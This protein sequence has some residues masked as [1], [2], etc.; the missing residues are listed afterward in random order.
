MTFGVG[1]TLR[2]LAALGLA[3][4]GAAFAGKAHQH[5]VARLDLAVDGGT[6]TIAVEMPLDALVGFERSPRTG[7]ERQAAAA[8][9]A[10]QG[11]LDAV[12][13]IRK[14]LQ[15]NDSDG[16]QISAWVLGQIG[17]AQDI[18]PLRGRLKDAPSPLIRAYIEHAMAVL[19]DP[20]GLAALIRNLESEDA[21][22]RT[23]AANFAG[24]AGAVSAQGALEKM[25]DDSNGDV[26]IRAAQA[27]LTLSH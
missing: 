6:V 25:L 15:G 5:G 8:A 18:E 27:L 9:L 24:D 4:C 12:A 19:G 14:N 17:S 20:E 23:Y 21:A 1:S 16:I 11:D 13:D 26:R 7:A 3:L 10:R 2:G 22:I